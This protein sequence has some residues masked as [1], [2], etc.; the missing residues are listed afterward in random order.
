[1]TTLDN[2]CAF[3]QVLAMAKENRAIWRRSTH[4]LQSKC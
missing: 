4:K 3:A 1:M 2:D